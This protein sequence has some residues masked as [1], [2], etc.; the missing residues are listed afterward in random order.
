M[1][2]VS[3]KIRQMN[4]AVAEKTAS[5]EGMGSELNKITSGNVTGER[6]N[7]K[8]KNKSELSKEDFMKLL[9][10]ELQNQNPL[11]PMDNKAMGS[12]LAQFTQL[13]QLEEMNSNIAKMSKSKDPNNKIY[14]ASLIG[15]SI[16][17][18]SVNFDHEKGK[19][20]EL[21]FNLSAPA[22]EVEIKVIDASG[23]EVKSIKLGSLNKGL[24]YY[25][26]DG[27]D[28]IGDYVDDGK[29]VYE[30]NASNEM[31]AN[32]HVDRG[33]SG[34]VSSVE[35][36]DDNVNL[37]LDNGSKVKLEDVRAVY[38]ANAGVSNDK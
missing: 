19:V 34:I 33:A 29:Y 7:V 25:K 13:E 20:Q 9:V 8:A 37:L 23:V 18:E 15:K 10:A 11:E 24:N 2:N 6:T 38:S 28:G 26:W 14:S 3:N 17:T 21:S 22:N 30:V 4:S 12:H 32:L 35:Y 31:G 5:G 16:K 27:R 1:I 36:I